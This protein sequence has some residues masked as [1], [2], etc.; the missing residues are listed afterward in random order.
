MLDNNYECLPVSHEQGETYSRELMITVNQ[1]QLQA[2]VLNWIVIRTDRLDSLY[3]IGIKEHLKGIW[4][5]DQTW[6]RILL[7]PQVIKSITRIIT[8][9]KQSICCLTRP[10]KQI[11]SE[12]ELTWYYLSNHHRIETDG[13]WL[14][15]IL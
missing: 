2:D 6:T 13:I 4:K 10:Y 8:K 1:L 7:D 14:L 9:L 15:N 5:T 11:E 3:T 12:H